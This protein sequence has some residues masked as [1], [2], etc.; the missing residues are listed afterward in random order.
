MEIKVKG[1]SAVVDTIR[2]DHEEGLTFLDWSELG[3]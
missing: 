1:E 2:Q 3:K